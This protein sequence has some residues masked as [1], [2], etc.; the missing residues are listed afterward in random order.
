MAARPS[1]KVIDIDA[2]V[3]AMAKKA[4]KKKAPRKDASQTALSIVERVTGGEAEGL[5][6]G[7]FP[8]GWVTSTTSPQSPPSSCGTRSRGLRLLLPQRGFEYEEL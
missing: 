3:R 1:R 4:A 6:F 8:I 7:P 2:L 5:S